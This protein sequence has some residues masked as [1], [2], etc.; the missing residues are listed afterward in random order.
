[1]HYWKRTFAEN[2]LHAAAV[3]ALMPLILA[4]GIQPAAA[5]LSDDDQALIRQLEALGYVGTAT[6][7]S[8]KV[9][10]TRLDPTR[11]A[12]GYRFFVSGHAPAAYLIDRTGEKVHTWQFPPNPFGVDHGTWNRGYHANSSIWRNARVLED[13]SLLAIYDGVG[14]VKIDKD[15]KLVWSVPNRAHHDLD[16]TPDGDIYVL[17][18]HPRRIPRIHPD[19][20]VV[21]DVVAVLDADGRERESYSILEALENSSEYGDLFAKHPFRVKDLLHPNAIRVLDGRVAASSPAFK[22]GNLLVSVAFMNAIIVIDPDLRE[23]VWAQVGPFKLQ[24]D[25]Q[26]TRDGNL[27]VFDNRGAWPVSRVLE[28]DIQTRAIVWRFQGSSETPFASKTSGSAERL[29]NGNTLIAETDGGRALEVTP[30]GEVV[31]E[32]YN[33]HRLANGDLASIFTIRWFMPSEN[34]FW[35]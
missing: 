17:R 35:E 15:S 5:Q 3:T 1:M 4:L 24:H 25:S 2:R 23:V 16:V 33:P 11:A 28:L 27:L 26:L 6:T 20:L 30:S 34:R 22:A 21:E 19:E 18:H 29:P 12:P 9:G 13:G 7:D 32:F 31:W 8:E 10:V 14:I